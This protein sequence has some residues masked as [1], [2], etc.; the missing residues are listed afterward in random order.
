MTAK[1]RISGLWKRTKRRPSERLANGFEVVVKDHLS[2][3][4]IA[5]PEFK[6]MRIEN[7]LTAT[8]EVQLG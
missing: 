6:W 3:L 8:R 7:F 5:L 2:A 4:K 1:P